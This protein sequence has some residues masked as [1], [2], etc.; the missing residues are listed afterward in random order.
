[1]ST[2]EDISVAIN[3]IKIK[4]QTLHQSFQNLQ[5]QTPF[6][7][8]PINWSDFD[9]YFTSLHS[10]LQHKHHLLQTFDQT[11]PELIS[12]CNNSNGSGL[13]DFIANNSDDP[14]A[15]LAQLPGAYAHAPDPASMVLEAVSDGFY[16]NGG[17]E[18]TELGLVRGACLVMLEGLVG[19]C[20][21]DEVRDK[22]MEIANKWVRRCV[23]GS[24]EVREVNVLGF[25]FLVGVYGLVDRFG[26]D[27]V[28]DC[29]VVVAR[30]RQAVELCRWMV[31][32]DKINGI[33]CYILFPIM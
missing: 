9:S 13:R 11:R 2:I 22:A 20:V 25:L 14:L 6:I 7:P 19:F 18:V 31:P 17:K 27:E 30:R 3:Q 26:V 24:E 4:K 29:F 33:V 16:S 12:F 8:I 32:S 15:L 23:L 5:N 28:V 21:G 10:S 1:M